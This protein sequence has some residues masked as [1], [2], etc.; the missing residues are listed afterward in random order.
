MRNVSGSGLLGK[1]ERDQ[2]QESQPIA[3]GCGRILKAFQD[4]PCSSLDTPGQEE[5][6]S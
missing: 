5:D 2:K 3:N 6:A 4:C 1:S